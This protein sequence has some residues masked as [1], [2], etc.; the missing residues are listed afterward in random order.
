MNRIYLIHGWDGH[1]ENCWFPW[2]KSELEK[3]GFEV[4]VP[5]LP[6][7]EEPKIK[8]W[9]DCLKETVTDPDEETYFIGHSIGCQTIMRFLETLPEETKIGGVVFVAGFFNLP[10][11]ETEEEK[12]IAQP[13]IET[14]IN[15]DKLLTLT[16]NF[17]AIFSD[18]DPEV[19][20]SDAEIFRGKLG[21][22]IIVEQG[23]GHFSDDDE[24]K[25]LPVALNELLKITK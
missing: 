11:L 25:E 20:L 18:D 1:P 4:I 15:T 23:K 5:S 7:S 3:R 19:S 22:K 12:E 8:E 17:V 10:N 24:V 2:L 14:P 9:V 16:D 6:H 13:W 21:A